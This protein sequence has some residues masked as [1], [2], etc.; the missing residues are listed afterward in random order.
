LDVKLLIVVLLFEDDVTLVSLKRFI[1]GD[2]ENTNLDGVNLNSEVV[3]DVVL[4]S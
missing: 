2:C 4:V 3:V 1:F